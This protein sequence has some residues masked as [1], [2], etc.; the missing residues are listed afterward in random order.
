MEIMTR[1]Q[2]NLQGALKLFQ[3]HSKPL[4]TEMKIDNFN[5]IPNFETQIALLKIE[6]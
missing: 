4:D 2:Q 5:Q 6:N 1:E 3:F